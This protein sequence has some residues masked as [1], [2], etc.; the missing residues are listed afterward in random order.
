MQWLVTLL[1]AVVGRTFTLLFGVLSFALAQR[2]ALVTGYILASAAL[3]LAVSAAIKTAVLAVR[4][5]M[6]PILVQ[7]TYFL[8]PSINSF[9]ASIVVIRLT[10]FVWR[11]TTSNLA[12]YADVPNRKLLM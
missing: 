5:V 11:W 6:P 3:F 8:P 1:G 4:V 7:A 2:I 10:Y 12:A 9:V